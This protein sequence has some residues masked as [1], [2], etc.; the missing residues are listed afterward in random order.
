WRIGLRKKTRRPIFCG[1]A[2]FGI[3]GAFRRREH[4]MALD[5]TWYTEQWSGQGGA[6]S[7]RI[8]TKLHDEQSPYQRIEV[9]ETETF[10]RLMTLDGLVMVTD[11]D[12]FI[13]HE[14][15]SH[16]ALYTHPDPQRVLIIGG[17]DCGTL[18]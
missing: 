6:I 7:L 9:Y 15:M 18:R 8:R 5:E 3:V 2:A 11:R 4:T 17:G 16:P 12:N 1:A 14:M 13:Y 10:G